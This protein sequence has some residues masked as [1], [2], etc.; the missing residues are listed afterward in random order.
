MDTL[1]C[2]SF[3]FLLAPARLVFQGPPKIREVPKG[4]VA[5]RPK[6]WDDAAKYIKKRGVV[7]KRAREILRTPASLKK[8]LAEA[9][10]AR[11]E[12]RVEMQNV[13]PEY[14]VEAML[15]LVR[16]DNAYFKRIIE[17]YKKKDDTKY[18]FVCSRV[19][20]RID[21]VDDPFFK[22]IF[23]GAKGYLIRREALRK[24]EDEPYKF[25]RIMEG[26]DEYVKPVSGKHMRQTANFYAARDAI[27]SLNS[28]RNLRTIAVFR[29]NIEGDYVK[30]LAQNRINQLAAKK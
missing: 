2:S 28:P 15:Y 23:E 30:N 5:E 26:L 20:K 19:I 11:D 4:S 17:I 25:D 29:G 8:F 7:E 24:I 22:K 16:K 6:V 21:L 3:S 13:E 27:T 12:G 14:I 1:N 9:E 10:T 18:G